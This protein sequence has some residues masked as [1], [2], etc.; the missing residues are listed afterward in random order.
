MRGQEAHDD[1]GSFHY[2]DAVFLVKMM[3]FVAAAMMS[4]MASGWLTM[5]LMIQL[6][7][8]QPLAA[9]PAQPI[10]QEDPPQ[11]VRPPGMDKRTQTTHTFKRNY[12]SPQFQLLPDNESGCWDF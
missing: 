3:V 9:P 1:D 8:T 11:L 10:P 4:M 2:A 12:A 6:A 5:Q 7:A